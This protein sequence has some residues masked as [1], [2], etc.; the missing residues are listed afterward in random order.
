[1]P[2]SYNTFHVK[3]IQRTPE[4][5]FAR[6]YYRRRFEGISISVLAV[7]QDVRAAYFPNLFLALFFALFRMVQMVS[8]RINKTQSYQKAIQV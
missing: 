3:T 4:S 6:H 7:T 5:I 8:S 2:V 1:L